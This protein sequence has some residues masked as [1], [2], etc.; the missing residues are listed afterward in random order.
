MYIKTIL[1]PWEWA[2]AFQL[3]KMPIII[4]YFDILG[5]IFLYN[6]KKA[7]EKGGTCRRKY[8]KIH[9]VELKEKII[10]M[11]FINSNRNKKNKIICCCSIS[12]NDK[13]DNYWSFEIELNT[14]RSIEV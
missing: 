1:K 10:Y 9:S 4:I 14:F 12:N 5:L 8:R 2:N 3:N 6:E 13:N 7:N 11:I